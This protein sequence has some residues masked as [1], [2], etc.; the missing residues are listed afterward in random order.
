MLKEKPL[1]RMPYRSTAQSRAYA[2]QVI[3]YAEGKRMDLPGSNIR[4][5][6]SRGYIKAVRKKLDLTQKRLAHLL[7]VQ[8]I[9]VQSWEQEVRFPDNTAAVLIELLNKH[10]QVKGWLENIS[11]SPM[12]EMQKKRK[13]LKEFNDLQRAGAKRARAMGIRSDEDVFAMLGKR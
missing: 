7:K 12:E 4:Y 5:I 9:T 6:H 13:V 1:P 2:K 11:A 10:P 8:L 3:A